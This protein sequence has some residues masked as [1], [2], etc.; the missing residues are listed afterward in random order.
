MFFL[1]KNSSISI[2]LHDIKAQ[3]DRIALNIEQGV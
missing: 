1:S 2:T 3:T